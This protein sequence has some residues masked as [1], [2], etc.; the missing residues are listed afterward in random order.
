MSEHGL[1]CLDVHSGIVEPG[2]VGMPQHMAVDPG[3]E[4]RIIRITGEHDLSVTIPDDPL[5]RFIKGGV[6]VAA[7]EAVQEDEIAVAINV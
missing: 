6:I 4:K 1:H 7:V 2:S 3:K 5:E